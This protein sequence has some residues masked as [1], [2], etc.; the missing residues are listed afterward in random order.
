MSN[1][2]SLVKSPQTRH[3]REGGGS[4]KRAYETS[5]APDGGFPREWQKQVISGFLRIRQFCSSGAL[6]SDALRNSF[7]DFI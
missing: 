1:F 7:F 2:D 4:G 3:P 6:V 5:E